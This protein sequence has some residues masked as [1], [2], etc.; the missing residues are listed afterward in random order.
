MEEI[1][2]G[3]QEAETFRYKINNAW[4]CN[5]KISTKDVMYNLTPMV[6][7]AV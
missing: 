7:T 3:G 5:Y 4:I 6:N 2:E 1:G